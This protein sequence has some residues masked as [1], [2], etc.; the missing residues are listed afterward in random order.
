MALPAIKLE[1]RHTYA[2]YLRWDDGERRE[3]I[4][5]RPYLMAPA[6]T[7]DHQLTSGKL[8]LQFGSFLKGKKRKV[9]YAPFDVRLFPKDDDSDDT[10]VQP[11][12]VVICDRSKLDRT[13]CAG[14][15]DTA[16]E[17]LSP[18]TARHDMLVKFHLYRK[19]GI[20]E[21][22]IVDPERKTVSAHI[23]KD[24]EYVVTTYGNED[25]APVHV[26][27]GLSID[28]SEVFADEDEFGRD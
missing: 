2:D 24:G 13:G 9:F 16:I 1:E 21:Y 7:L 8:H 11:D 15:P 5:G 17:I 27:E 4:Y 18:S 14:A 3:I 25:S 12:I 20:R 19:A 28:L 10:I 22:W 6:P 23:L 26:L